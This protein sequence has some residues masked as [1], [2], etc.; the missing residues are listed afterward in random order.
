MPKIKIDYVKA[1][2]ELKTLI[3]H[4][5][6]A[7]NALHKEYAQLKDKYDKVVE[8]GKNNVELLYEQRG[9]I[10]FLETKI[11]KLTE[12]IDKEKYARK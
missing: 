2:R 11:V 12:M 1:Y 7:H 6:D 8:Q 4:E 10:G 5:R 3:E 9:V